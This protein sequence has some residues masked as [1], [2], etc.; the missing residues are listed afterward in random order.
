MTAESQ[1]GKLVGANYG[2]PQRV[3]AERL[4][5]TS[6]VVLG[7]FSLLAVWLDPYTPTSHP[8]ATFLLLFGYVAYALFVM[9]VVWLADGPLLAWRTLRYR[10]TWFEP[11][12]LL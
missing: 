11:E 1:N 3:R 7:A 5:A 9:S 12:R 4:I 10:A 6:R 2:P 8:V